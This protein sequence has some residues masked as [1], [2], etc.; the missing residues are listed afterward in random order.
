[1][2]GRSRAK[3]LEPELPSQGKL[4]AAL[5]AEG[6]SRALG[7]QLASAF[8]RDLPEDSGRTNGRTAGLSCRYKGT[9][10]EDR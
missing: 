10:M 5:L 6:G 9:Y 7:Q 8:E 1:M 4:D 3:R 2:A